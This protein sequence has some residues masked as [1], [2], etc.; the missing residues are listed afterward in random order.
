MRSSDCSVIIIKTDRA[1]RFFS[2][3]GFVRLMGTS[4]MRSM[5]GFDFTLQGVYGIW[6]GFPVLS[7]R[8]VTSRHSFSSPAS[9]LLSRDLEGG[10]GTV[11]HFRTP[12]TGRS[13]GSRTRPL[14]PSLGPDYINAMEAIMSQRKDDFIDSGLA[15]ATE[16]RTHRRFMLAICGELTGAKLESEIARLVYLSSCACPFLPPS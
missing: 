16:K 1:E 8:G 2:R 10:L 15:I 4:D 6:N 3:A 14:D 11:P 12:P 5:D 9:A 7:E 13:P